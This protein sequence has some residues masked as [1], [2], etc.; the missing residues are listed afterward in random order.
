MIGTIND[1][2]N[3]CQ[4]LRANPASMLSQRFNLPQGVN[5]NDPN[6]IIQ[7]LLNTNQVSQ[8]QVNSLMRMR[9]NPILRRL[10]GGF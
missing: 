3:L 8:A 10:F 9:D 1:F 5:V 6:S 2:I 7:H 4:Q